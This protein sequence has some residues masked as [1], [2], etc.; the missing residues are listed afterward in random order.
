MD[1]ILRSRRLT[2]EIMRRAAAIQGHMDDVQTRMENMR[3]RSLVMSDLRTW[4]Q[5]VH[6]EWGITQPDP[7]TVARLVTDPGTLRALARA[8]GVGVEDGEGE[9]P[10]AGSRG[11][12]GEGGADDGGPM[13]GRRVAFDMSGVE[14]AEWVEVCRDRQEGWRLALR[15]LTWLQAHGA[16]HSVSGS[17][18]R[19][20]LS[21]ALRYLHLC[22]ARPMPALTRPTPQ[23]LSGQPPAAPA[24][25]TTG[26]PALRS[27]TPGC[28]P[29]PC[30]PP[31]SRPTREQ[32]QSGAGRRLAG[33]RPR[34][35][36]QPLQQLQHDTHSAHS[37]EL[38]PLLLS[39]RGVALTARAASSSSSQSDGH[40]PA[41]GPPALSVGGERRGEGV[42]PLSSR[43]SPTPAST[44][45]TTGPA[46]ARHP[47]DASTPSPEAPPPPCETRSPDEAAG[48]P[49]PVSP[50]LPPQTSSPP[51]PPATS[52]PRA[53]P[54]P[55]ARHATTEAAAAA[56]T[57]SST[58]PPPAPPSIAADG[59]SGWPSA[60]PPD[61]PPPPPS[62]SPAHSRSQG[63]AAGSAPPAGNSSNSSLHT[64]A[65]RQAC[66]ARAGCG[67]A[68]AT[69]TA[70]A[71]LSGAV[72]ASMF[73][74]RLRARKAEALAVGALVSLLSLLRNEQSVV[75]EMALCVL[76]DCVA[77]DPQS[78]EM[79]LAGSRMGSLVHD[80]LS[81]ARAPELV[82]Q[83][84]RVLACMWATDGVPE[85]SGARNRA[86][87][88][89]VSCKLLAG[90]WRLQ[91]YS[92][93]GESMRVLEI[94]LSFG[95]SADDS[96]GSSGSGCSRVH[97]P[98]SC[99]SVCGGGDVIDEVTGTCIPFQVGGT[100]N[101]ATREWSMTRSNALLGN[102]LL[103]Q[104]YCDLHGAWG[105][106]STSKA[107]GSA[108]SFV[109]SQQ[110][111]PRVFRLYREDV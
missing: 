106:Y 45:A 63:T 71:E 58:A 2:E 110:R 83:A 105:S 16:P 104:G 12:A 19:T 78:T 61:S 87:L 111:A 85:A 97:G 14:A 100:V 9:Q 74:S 62:Q 92:L 95:R 56:A 84:S 67:V 34:E 98:T 81:D 65:T 108:A 64:P 54:T 1:E 24:P 30:P 41:V 5:V 21:L 66:E 89:W 77:G 17:L 3:L 68:T 73:E 55:A 26:A 51:Q 75:Q 52:H 31:C 37:V 33:E 57:P 103:Y 27:A 53:S 93:R 6:C 76:A 36:Q 79:L 102:T 82:K 80:K 38:D 48:P 35:R 40:T 99:V 69:A 32:R 43:P 49:G 29:G 8:G 91:E 4:R 28:D 86:F 15:M 7:G 88:E 13:A 94:S 23:P 22:L 50:L 107:Q 18:H 39:G 59:P 25:A 96:S 101:L 46:P 72:R 11:S 44:S 90:V 70:T 42:S 10:E 20:Q 47:H 109:I 60:S